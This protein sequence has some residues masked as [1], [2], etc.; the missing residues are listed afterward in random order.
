MSCTSKWFPGLPD[1][2]VFIPKMPIMVWFGRPWD[3]K[4]WLFYIWQFSVYFGI[5]IAICYFCGH[6]DIFFAILVCCT[7]KNLATLV[8]SV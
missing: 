6:F 5:F 1:G 7:K 3:K 2:F 8:V 4:F